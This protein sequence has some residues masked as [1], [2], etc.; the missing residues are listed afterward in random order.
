M[1]LLIWWFACLIDSLVYWWID[2]SSTVNFR[3]VH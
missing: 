3:V 1:V 2:R